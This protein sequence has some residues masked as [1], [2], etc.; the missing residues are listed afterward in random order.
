MHPVLQSKG[1]MFLLC[2]LSTLQTKR[3]DKN[4]KEKSKKSNK[5]SGQMK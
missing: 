5:K 2:Y 4:I 1:R 3:M